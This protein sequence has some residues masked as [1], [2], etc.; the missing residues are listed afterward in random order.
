MAACN[1]F[2]YPAQLV[3]SSSNP[4]GQVEKGVVEGM[5]GIHMNYVQKVLRLRIME[6]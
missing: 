3:T 6:I 5:S 4:V 2:A 1:R